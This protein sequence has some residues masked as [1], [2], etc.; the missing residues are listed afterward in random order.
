MRICRMADMP[1]IFKQNITILP[2]T[3]RFTTLIP[4]VAK[5]FKLYMDFLSL[6]S[7]KANLFL[8]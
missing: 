5:L 1:T 3:Y 4:E 8:T 7:E 6:N 2:L